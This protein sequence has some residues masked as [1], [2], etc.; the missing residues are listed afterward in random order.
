VR[1]GFWPEFAYGDGAL[2]RARARDTEFE[3]EEG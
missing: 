1:N 2:E 3:T